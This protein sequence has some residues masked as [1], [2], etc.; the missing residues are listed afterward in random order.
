VVVAPLQ[1][2]LKTCYELFKTQTNSNNPHKDIHFYIE[3]LLCDRLNSTHAIGDMSESKN[4]EDYTKFNE[5]YEEFGSR[6][7]KSQWIYD[8]L[9]QRVVKELPNNAGLTSSAAYV[10]LLKSTYKNPNP[11]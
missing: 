2:S 9:P 3:P 11:Q 1:K 4:K 7:S 6:M 8:L 5:F 10:K